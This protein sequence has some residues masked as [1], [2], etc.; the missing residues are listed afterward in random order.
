MMIKIRILEGLELR[1]LRKLVLRKCF[2]SSVN[3]IDEIIMVQDFP[4]LLSFFT[5]YLIVFIVLFEIIY[6]DNLDIRSIL[7]FFSFL[8]W[9][10]FEFFSF[11]LNLFL[12]FNV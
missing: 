9:F 5:W 11:R 2:V 3:W 4:L 7:Y 8:E 12:I 6:Y 10:E 1:K